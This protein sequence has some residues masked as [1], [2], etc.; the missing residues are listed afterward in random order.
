MRRRLCSGGRTSR[1]Q[2]AWR[3]PTL[4]LRAAVGGAAGALLVLGFALALAVVVLVVIAGGASAEL[5]ADSGALETE[6]LAQAVLQIALVREVVEGRVVDEKDK[7]GRAD[8]DLGG[9]VDPQSAAL[10]GGR[11]VAANR[12]AHDFVELGRGDTALA[13][14]VD[15]QRVIE[16]GADMVAGFGGGEDDGRV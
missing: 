15:A 6:C 3:P 16:D 9:V 14:V 7:G 10:A 4:A 11:V 12:L 1:A 8:L 2:A 5:Q 13:L